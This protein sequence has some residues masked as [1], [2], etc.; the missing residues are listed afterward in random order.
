[1]CLFLEIL[2][3]WLGSNKVSEM[4]ESKGYSGL[5]FRLLFIA[6]WFLGAILSTCLGFALSSSGG[7]GPSF[8]AVWVYAII[9]AFLGIGA[10]TLLVAVLPE[11]PR[12]R[13]YMDDYEEYQRTGRVHDYRRDYDDG[14]EEGRRRSREERRSRRPREDDRDDPRQYDD[15][16]RSDDRY[17]E[18]DRPRR[19]DRDDDD[20]PRRP[21][22]DEDY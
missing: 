11:P 12:K 22:R 18:D 17:R 3:L 14:Y 15:R 20:R 1:M 8:L 5:L 7:R 2:I 13:G 16:P 21:R 6:S 4:A 9:G 10:V 19:R